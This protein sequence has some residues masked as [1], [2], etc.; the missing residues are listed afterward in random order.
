[1]KHIVLIMH[2][3]KQKI[4]ASVYH[5]GGISLLCFFFSIGSFG[6]K[7]SSSVDVENIKIG[8]Q[9][10]F[11]IEVEADS[12]A[13]VVFPE[14]QTFAPLEMV[15]ISETDTIRVKDRITLQRIYALTQFDSGA[16]KL[17]R[18]KIQVEDRIFYTDSLRIT[19]ANVAVD[20]I[21]QP[22]YDIKTHIDVSKNST[23]SVLVWLSILLVL[24]VI[25]G[26][27]YWFVFRKKPLTEEEE[28]ALL[29][30]YDRA[31][32]E[33]KKLENSRY[34]IHSEYK[35]YYSELT[36]IVRQYIEEDVHVSAL[37]S[38]TDE[39]IEKLEL[40][41][42]SGNLKIDH[43]TIAQ[44]KRVLQTADLVKFAKSKPDDKTA[45]LDRNYIEDIVIKTKEALPEPTEEELLENE[46]YLEELEKKRRK[47]KTIIAIAAVFLGI[48]V[49]GAA[50]TAYYGFDYTKDT[51]L[52]HPTKK[53][54]EGEWV[55]S[56]YG[57]P[58]VIIETPKVLLRKNV[59][60]PAEAKATIKEMQYFTFS[61][62]KAFFNIVINTA[63][64]N[65]EVEANFE[66][67]VE[68][69]IKE[70]EAAGVKNIITKKE[71]FETPSDVKGLKTYGKGN[72]TIPG[73]EVVV[74]GEYLILNFGGKGFMQQVVIQWEKDDDYAKKIIDRILSSVDVKKEI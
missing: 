7:V 27:L 52:R 47:K 23:I 69:V 38:T 32:L 24:L 44:F 21:A 31:L 6:Q 70:M 9:V 68:A 19:V 43:D 40:L 71:E 67:S 49:S 3:A 29:P 46:A 39:L 41:K 42:D 11:K 2:I 13:L 33:L 1:M 53:L 57:Y 55:K 18:Q 48:L 36:G 20:T 16:Y 35:T 65:G 60:I 12:T 45:E 37:E 10:K 30:A 50:A 58:P 25:G 66:K 34:L 63:S 28:I 61:S 14:G 5:T 15:E 74:E 26:L 73:T 72:F 64:L 4:A 17:P 8:E 56:E 59:E 54:L 22:M 62:S 51:V